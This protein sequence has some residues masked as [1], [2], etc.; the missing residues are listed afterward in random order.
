MCLKVELCL[1]AGKS[2]VE[3]GDD[4]VDILDADREADEVLGEVCCLELLR[5]S[6]E[7]VVE[8]GWMISDFASPTLARCVKSFTLFTTE[9][10][11]SRPPLTPKTTTPPKPCFR[12]RLAT[13][14]DGSFS[15][16]E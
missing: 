1:H 10:P 12:M 7:W 8:A 9:S 14:C 6:W 13:S 4:I 16:P 11:A 2:L 15:S 5:L 3:V